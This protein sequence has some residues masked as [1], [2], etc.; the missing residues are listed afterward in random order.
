MAGFLYFRAGGQQ[1]VTLEQAQAWGLGYTFDGSCAGCACNANNP[2]E[3][4]G[5]VFA[6]VRRQNGK[7]IGIYGDQQT[8][9][10]LPTVEGRPEL[11]LGYWNDAKPTPD[12]LKRATLL[13]G[14]KILLADGNKWQIPI[15][16]HFDDSL[17]AWQSDLPA[18]LDYD[19]SGKVVRGTPL[20]QYRTLWEL[21]TPL[22]ESEVEGKPLDEGAMY[23][24]IV[25]LLQANYVVDLP[26][27]VALHALADDDSLALVTMTSCRYHQLVD[28]ID[29]L[30]KKTDSP[31][32]AS[33]S[34]SSVGDAA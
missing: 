19:E 22:A 28:W 20:E 1:K 26:E 17:S 33:G 9:R 18:Y 31:S 5:Y 4:P 25:A 14:P 24:A 11:W 13:N 21:T 12:C 30:Q 2:S 23:T 15:V 8:W 7:A 6:D 34:N 32:E 16:R 29:T 10:K 3:Q 27:L